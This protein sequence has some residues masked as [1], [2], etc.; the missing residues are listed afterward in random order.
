LYVKV[1]EQ[2]AKDHDATSKHPSTRKRHNHQANNTLL[3]VPRYADLLADRNNEDETERGRALVSSQ[4]SWRSEMARWIGEA[5]AAEE[6]E[7]DDIDDSD[8]EIFPL[9]LSAGLPR[10]T[11]WPKMT[12]ARLFKGR[13]PPPRPTQAEIDAEVEADAREAIADAEED[14]VLDDGAIEID[15]DEEYIY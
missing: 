3:T 11:K 14:D 1:G 13:P 8:D 15:D 4:D 2:I 9:R 5:R 6:A 10:L 12:L 7:N